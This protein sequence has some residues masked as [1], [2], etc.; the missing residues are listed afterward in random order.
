MCH[1]RLSI[2]QTPACVNACPEGAI[3]IEIVNVAKWRESIDTSPSN[4][5][6][7][8]NDG[9]LSTTRVTLPKTLPPN[10]TP[11]GVTNVVPEHPHW[12]L[13]VMTVLTQLAV[14]AFTTIWLSQVFGAAAH[15]GT[16]ALASLIVGGLALSA[17]TLHLGR[18]IHAYRAIRMWRRSWLSREVLLFSAFSG[19][20]GV[21]R[22]GVV[23]R[24]AGRRIHRRVDS[25]RRHRG[26]DVERLHLPRAI[27]TGV[28]H[29]LHAAAVQSH[30]RRPRP[31]LRGCR[32]WRQSSL[33]GH[34]R[35]DDGERAVR[36]AGSAPVPLHFV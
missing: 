13:V 22:G 32:R 28:E 5:G 35:S 1:G 18:P 6:L 29:A 9:S 4:A 36:V 25:C 12:P 23:V 2:G 17:S 15:L 21:V 8:K 20:A 7:P 24:S 31:A 16:A 34:R 14:G 10:A 3:A 33:A 27:T 11:V 19:I 30:G 26:R